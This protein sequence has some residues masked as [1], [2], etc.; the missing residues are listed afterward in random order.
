MSL[1]QR[2]GQ[3][4]LADGVEVALSGLRRLIQTTT[5]TAVP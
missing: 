2:A 5:E 1:A 4:G 3:L